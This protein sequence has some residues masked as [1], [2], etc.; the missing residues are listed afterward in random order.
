MTTSG[1]LGEAEVGGPSL[2]IVPKTG[3]NTVKG[4][5]YLSGRDGGH[6]RQ[7]LHA[8]TC[9]SAG[10]T[11]PGSSTKMWDFNGGVG[12]PIKKDRVV[13]L[14]HVP[15]RGQPS[16]RARHVREPQRRRSDQVDLRRRS[17]TGPPPW[18]HRFA[19]PRCASPRRPTPRNKF[20]IFWDEQMPCEGAAWPGATTTA[21]R[22][23]GDNEIIAGG[24]AAPTPSCQ[25]D[26]RAGNRRAYR[27]Y[28]TRFR[29][30]SWQSPMTNQLLLEAGV[31]NYASRYLGT[32][33][34][35][36]PAL[37]F[38]QV[39]EQ[40]AAGCAANGGIPNLV[41]RA[42]NYRARAGSASNNWRASL[43]YVGAQAL[44][45]FGYQGGYL[46]RRSLPL[47]EQPVRDLPHEQRE[48][49]SDQRDHRLQP[50]PA[51]RPL[52]RVLRAG[53]VDEGP[54][55]AAGRAPVRSRD[56]HLSRR[57][58]GR[59]PLPADASYRS[60]KPRASIRTRT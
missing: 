51:A 31:G 49:G 46:M 35:G 28:G 12:G 9:K 38:I 11:T 59:R 52:R 34:P 5:V 1:G 7:Q 22:Q 16:D 57:H 2:N 47:H 25:R 15:R 36:T 29:Q 26:G 3:G 10:L 33:M 53:P 40:C 8:T 44:T 58:H 14:L 6:G 41:Y 45:K 50:D 17:R 19:R 13:V 39:T 20:R 55:H 43:S 23:S 18:P 21:C 56:E 48:A 27:D 37:D 60:R 4:S 24:T 54:D 42:R 30:V 32:P